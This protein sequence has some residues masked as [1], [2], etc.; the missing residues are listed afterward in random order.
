[1]ISSM[2]EDCRDR[3]VFDYIY[4]EVSAQSAQGVFEALQEYGELLYDF[5]H[6]EKVNR[7]LKK[8]I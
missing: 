6:K 5:N 1:M 2:L 8:V 3:P 7:N 4:R